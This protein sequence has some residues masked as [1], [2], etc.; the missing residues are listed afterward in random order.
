M[1]ARGRNRRLGPG[2]Y[3]LSSDVEDAPPMPNSPAAEVLTGC[4]RVLGRSITHMARLVVFLALP[5]LLVAWWVPI[6]PTSPPVHPRWELISSRIET[7]RFHVGLLVFASFLWLLGARA[8]RFALLGCVLGAWAIIP[9]MSWPS[10]DRRALS[11]APSLRVLSVNLGGELAKEGLVIEALREV[12]PD[13]LVIQ[14]YTQSW[15]RRLAARVAEQLPHRVERPRT[16]NFGMAVFSGMPWSRLDQ[17]EFPTSRTPQF[18]MEL[19][20]GGTSVALY[21][22]HLL[23]PTHGLYVAHR[24]ECAALLRR[25]GG[26]GRHAMA[27]GDFNFVDHGAMGRSLHDLGF[28]DAHGLAGGGRGATWPRNDW[29]R[30]LPGIRIDH[31]Y[32][33]SGLTSTEAWV[34]RPTGS[35]HLPIGCEVTLTA[36]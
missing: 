6:D 18:R 33:G 4:A 25:L 29:L 13:V 8:W 30:F 27:I 26:E 28:L 32:L 2:V 35:D 7:L 9:S 11:G 23:P 20:L 22:V 34:D 15:Q 16:D 12:K 36:E 19:P 1:A 14:E 3:D 31:V 21:A 10:A 5:L 17:F 24:S